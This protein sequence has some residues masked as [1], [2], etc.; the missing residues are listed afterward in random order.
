MGAACSGCATAP[1]TTGVGY[2]DRCYNAALTARERVEA[3]RRAVIEA[4]VE[5]IDARRAYVAMGARPE[6]VRKDAAWFAL[7][8]AVDAA[9]AAGV[10]PK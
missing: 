2:C 3:H 9:R 4:A 1:A 6:G 7:V 10:V 8:D 5:V